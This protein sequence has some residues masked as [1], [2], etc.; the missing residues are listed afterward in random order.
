LRFSDS[1]TSFV[2]VLPD[3]PMMATFMI[4]PQNQ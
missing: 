4:M 1:R 2:P 3:A